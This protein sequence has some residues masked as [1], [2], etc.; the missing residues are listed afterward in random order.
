MSVCHPLNFVVLRW[1]STVFHWAYSFF[2]NLTLFRFFVHIKRLHR[3][4]AFAP[5]LNCDRVIGITSVDDA[6]SFILIVI[7][8][9]LVS[10]SIIQC[11]WS[12]RLPVVIRID[13]LCQ[14]FFC[15]LLSSSPSLV[16]KIS[17][18]W[19]ISHTFEVL[20]LRCRPLFNIHIRQE[21]SIIN[22]IVFLV[23]FVHLVAINRGV[24]FWFHQRI[25]FYIDGTS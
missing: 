18:L 23:I 5:R 4:I 14:T 10:L 19:R 7:H 12:V 15:R 13:P 16:H 8:Y 24:S 22:G 1:E 11:S 9:H 6:I 21:C 17:F 25:F 3:R 20:S 2:W